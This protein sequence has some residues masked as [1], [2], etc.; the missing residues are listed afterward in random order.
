MSPTG[1]VE[2]TKEP[3]RSEAVRPES[4]QLELPQGQPVVYGPAGRRGDQTLAVN[5]FW[6]ERVRDDALLRS[7]RPH[8]LPSA[9]AAGPR[10]S[11][12][13]EDMPGG[14]PD[15]RQLLTMVLQQNSQLK[16]EL[17][18]LKGQI[19]AKGQYTVVE[20]VERKPEKAD[21]REV[22]AQ[23]PLNAKCWLFKME[24]LMRPSQCREVE[25]SSEPPAEIQPVSGAAGL[26]GTKVQQQVLGQVTQTLSDLVARLSAVSAPAGG[27]QNGRHV[28]D[29]VPGQC[30]HRGDAVGQPGVVAAGQHQGAQGGHGSSES[31]HPGGV[32]R[33]P[34]AG[35]PGQGLSGGGFGNSG[36]VP[37]Y[38]NHEGGYGGSGGFNG[39]GRDGHG[40]GSYGM[41]RMTPYPVP[42]DMMWFQGMNETIRSVE[43]PPLPG[44][45]EGELGGSVVGDWLTLVG[46]VMKDL[47]VSSCAWWE[48][49]MKASGEAYQ[50][51]LMSDPVQRLHVAPSMPSECA[52]TWARL[53]QRGQSML[54][55][56]L[57]E[58]L[59]SEVLASRSTNTVEILYRIYTRYQPG[60]L[61]EKALLLRQLV[62]GKASTNAGEF[63]EQV[64][65]WKRNLRR[66][67]EL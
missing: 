47:S 46:P 52:T 49:V 59:K 58:G 45:R 27:V 1:A 51:W 56:A 60:G 5:P 40:Y 63:L 50:Q 7:M 10:A 35:V 20:P 42:P 39:G 53:E 44:I 28:S 65:G 62:D 31:Q 36:Q 3:G 41:P 4:L 12:S 37:G 22:L 57:P 66:A 61:G 24:R 29:G 11:S 34:P 30:Q 2:E 26:D 19:E 33:Q 55:A 17:D 64:R 8:E 32:G 14:L 43:L 54:L 15:M 18:S 25:N 67:Q 13:E 21:Q 23:I 38:G 16:Q 9:E 6:S 48:A